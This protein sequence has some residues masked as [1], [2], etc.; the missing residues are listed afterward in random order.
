MKFKFMTIVP[1]FSVSQLRNNLISTGCVCFN[2]FFV[3]WGF[4]SL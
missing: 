2:K 3:I 1:N 4:Q